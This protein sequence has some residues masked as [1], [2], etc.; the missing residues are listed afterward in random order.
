MMNN[1]VSIIIPVYNVEPY[2]EDCILSVLNQTYKSIEVIAIDDCSTDKSIEVL[3][4]AIVG[5]PKSDTVRII[6]NTENSLGPSEARNIGIRAAKG[7]YIFFLDSDDELPLDSIESLISVAN[8]YDADFVMGETTVVG[9]NDIIPN[10]LQIIRNYIQIKTDKSHFFS[11]DDLL[12][13]FLKK[14]WEIIVWNKLLKRNFVIQSDLFFD[15]GILHEDELWSFKLAMVAKSMSFCYKQTYIYKI[16][17]EGSITSNRSN[18][19]NVESCIIVAK[20]MIEFAILKNKI[21]LLARYIIEFKVAMFHLIYS[22]KSFNHKNRFWIMAF[23]ETKIPFSYLDMPN[24]DLE[25]EFNRKTFKKAT[26]RIKINFLLD[27]ITK[28]MNTLDVHKFRVFI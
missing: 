5:H 25:E 22:V 19:K 14:E 23:N 12:D 21:N 15:K 24:I 17:K 7:E 3:K 28:R 20:R 8:K 27:A 2:I 4:D 13:S 9:E 18:P 6:E 16:R 11:N 26:L 1:L 10:Y